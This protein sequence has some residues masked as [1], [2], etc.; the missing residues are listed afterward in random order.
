MKGNDEKIVK[1][2]VKIEIDIR[3]GRLKSLEKGMKKRK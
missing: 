2:M 1:E 3:R